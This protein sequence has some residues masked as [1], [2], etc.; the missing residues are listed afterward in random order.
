MYGTEDGKNTDTAVYEVSVLTDEIT[1]KNI[2]A[3]E[4]ENDVASRSSIAACERYVY[5][6]RQLPQS[7]FFGFLQRSRGVVT[8][9][10]SVSD[11]IKVLQLSR[12]DIDEEEASARESTRETGESTLEAQSDDSATDDDNTDE[13]YQLNMA[14]GTRTRNRRMPRRLADIIA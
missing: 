14:A 7:G 9:A 11:Y 1:E 6:V 13:H 2:A 4:I 5:I 12:G 8:G 3:N 10:K